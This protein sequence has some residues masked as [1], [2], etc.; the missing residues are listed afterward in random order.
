M[1]RK[2]SPAR[3][4]SSNNST[5]LVG[6]A[7][8]DGSDAS[9]VLAGLNSPASLA[10]PRII[11]ITNF[12]G[13]A[14][15]TTTSVA[16]A[17]AL[18]QRGHRTL[19][20]DLDPQANATAWLSR[21]PVALGS[22]VGEW[23]LAAPAGMSP[24]EVGP[25]DESLGGRLHLLP[26]TTALAD[27]EEVLGRRK[28]YQ[29]ALAQGLSA[30][31]AG[32]DYLVLDCA[33]SIGPLTRMALCAATDYLVPCLPEKFHFD[34]LAKIHQLAGGVQAK[35]N[36]GLTLAGVLFCR[37]NAGQK[38]QVAHSI[39]QA[40]GHVYGQHQLLPSIRQDAAVGKAQT[41]GELLH[42]FDALS[43]ALE[44]YAALTEHL[45]THFTH[46]R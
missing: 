36:A 41:K 38:G 16:L 25:G 39:V 43:N 35:Y 7:A 30:Y 26:A 46:P 29:Y 23:L 24:R 37:Y 21:S 12:K 18:A 42:R 31:A 3:Q 6:L 20:V 17:S 5:S 1:S 15:K 33:P 32:Y 19:L 27:Q 22:S 13:G 4:T 34:G 14:G 10:S 44:D 2:I 8:L 45:L 28:N 40:A 11:A 9:A